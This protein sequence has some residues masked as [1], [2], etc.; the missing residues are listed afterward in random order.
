MCLAAHLQCTLDLVHAFTDVERTRRRDDFDMVPLEAESVHEIVQ[1]EFDAAAN[2]GAEWA[3]R[4]RCQQN[5][6]WSHVEFNPSRHRIF[7][8]STVGTV[9]AT[10]DSEDSEDS[11]Q[12]PAAAR[13]YPSVRPVEN[14]MPTPT[15]DALSDP[16]IGV[17]P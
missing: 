10:E 13:R 7:P 8:R 4:R 1:R 14:S 3:D 17:D 2:S 9:M 11:P 16:V 12:E 15:V 6:S 5:P